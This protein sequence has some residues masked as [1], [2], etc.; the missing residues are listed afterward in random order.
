[1]STVVVDVRLTFHLLLLPAIATNLVSEA[2]DGVSMVW[3]AQTQNVSTYSV[4]VPSTI[5]ASD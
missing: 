5:L 2:M 1:M 3:L 4:L